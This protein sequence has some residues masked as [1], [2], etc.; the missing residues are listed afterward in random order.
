MLGE[1]SLFAVVFLIEL[2]TLDSSDL[3]PVVAVCAALR[4]TNNFLALSCHAVRIDEER[5]PVHIFARKQKNSS[6]IS[7]SPP[8]SKFK[9]DIQ[10]NMYFI[11]YLL[12]VD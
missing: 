9:G 6:L 3:R 11:F 1:Y 10:I 8:R 2:W 5:G 12:A 4:W 7:S